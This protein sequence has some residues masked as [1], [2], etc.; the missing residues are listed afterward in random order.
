MA[1]AIR[2]LHFG[3]DILSSPGRVFASALKL[4]ATLSGSPG[5]KRPARYSPRDRN[6]ANLMLLNNFSIDR[7]E[8]WRVKRHL[9]QILLKKSEV[10]AKISSRSQ[11]VGS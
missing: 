3:N 2:Q 7:G 9:I 8:P 5:S 11:R 6:S 4:D 10:H 1:G